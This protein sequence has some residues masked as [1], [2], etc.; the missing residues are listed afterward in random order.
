[1]NREF[2]RAV[3]K[4]EDSQ[5]LL[6]ELAG[7]W[8][9]AKARAF[10]SGFLSSARSVTFVVQACLAHV[11]GF[12]TW[13]TA[14]Q[15]SMRHDPLARFL[16]LARNESEKLGVRPI[17]YRGV[18]TGFGADGQPRCRRV[19]RFLSLEDAAVLPP[20]GSVLPTCRRHLKMLAGI[21]L[22]A[23]RRFAPHV[24]ADSLLVS[25]IRRAE[26]AAPPDVGVCPL[27]RS[28]SRNRTVTSQAAPTRPRVQ[29]KSKS[30]RADHVR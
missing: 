20:T 7:T 16:Q 30:P 28:G 25:R 14:Q 15:E 2:E 5:L 10:F 1:M 11:P 22:E 23:A 26:Q 29:R 21:L 3:E 18:A 17:H 27:H 19:Y 12:A 8:D 13:W 24:K 9:D 4:L 6:N